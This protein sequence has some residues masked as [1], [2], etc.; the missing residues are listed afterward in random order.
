MELVSC[1]QGAAKLWQIREV[2]DTAVGPWS[3]PGAS[4]SA[5]RRCLLLIRVHRQELCKRGPSHEIEEEGLGFLSVASKSFV[6]NTEL[7]LPGNI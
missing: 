6:Q 3:Q 5:T 2:E 1:G 4:S 7:S